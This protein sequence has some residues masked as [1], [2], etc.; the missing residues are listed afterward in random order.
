MLGKTIADLEVGDV[1]EPVRYVLTSFMCAEYA[2]AV[3]DPTEC[4]YAETPD[5]GRQIRPPTMIHSDKMRLLEANCAAERRM[6][7]IRTGDARIHYE[8]D[9]VQH[10]PAY[11]GE[12]LVL[13]GRIIDKYVKRGREF[14][15]YEISVETS[16]GRLVTTYRD[17]TLLRYRK[18]DEA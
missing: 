5:F 16:D 13:S 10:G 14:L 11:V 6:A 3:E 7:G 15:Q 8:Y 18:A 12:E 1:F 17:R 4:Y 9:A 2:H